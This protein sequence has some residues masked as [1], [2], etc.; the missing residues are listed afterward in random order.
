M[1]EKSDHSLKGFRLGKNTH[2]EAS[3]CKNR[4]EPEYPSPT[5]PTHIHPPANKRGYS[6]TSERAYGKTS[7]NF[8]SESRVN[9][10]GHDGPDNE[11]SKL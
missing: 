3:S 5:N 8:A 11:I 9:N 10:I 7:H 6:W 1:D 2:Y 4:L